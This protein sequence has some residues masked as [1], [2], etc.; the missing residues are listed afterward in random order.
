[1]PQTTLEIFDEQ[2]ITYKG[3]NPDLNINCVKEDEEGITIDLKINLTRHN[4]DNDCDVFFQ[5]YDNRGAGTQPKNLGKIKELNEEGDNVFQYNI[6]NIKK[7][8]AKFRITVSKIG[9]FKDK[10]VIRLIGKAEIPGFDDESDKSK[11]KINSLLPTKEMEIGTP[12][13]VDM[14]PNRL[15]Y[16]VLKKGCNIKSKLDSNSDPVQKS[17]I[18]TSAIRSLIETYLTDHRYE[19]CIYKKQW[20]ELISKKIGDPI[21]EFPSSYVSLDE[22]RAVIENSCKNWIEQVTETMVSNLIDQNGKRLIDKHREANFK[23]S[24]ITYGEEEG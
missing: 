14:S 10:K 23:T 13:N 24:E 4:F 6:P 9:K 21:D 18:Y 20:F 15:P 3:K 1:M 5:S 12:F 2:R 17:L 22:G 8:D 19:D 7:E 16:L 11:Q